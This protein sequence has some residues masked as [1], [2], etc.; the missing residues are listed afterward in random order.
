LLESSAEVGSEP[1][2]SSAVGSRSGCGGQ[3]DLAT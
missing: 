3:L 2:C 1:F